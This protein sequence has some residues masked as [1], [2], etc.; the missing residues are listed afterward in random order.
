MSLLL[1]QSFDEE[2]GGESPEITTTVLPNGRVGAGYDQPI[3]ATGGTPPYT[4]TLDSGSL[5]TGL[6][7]ETDGQLHGTPTASGTFVFTVQVEDDALE[8]DTQEL[9][10]QIVGRQG[11]L[12]LGVG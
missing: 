10:I 8:T 4:F 1:F 6:T 7:L 2:V 11:L 12:L 5:P 3:V 9:T